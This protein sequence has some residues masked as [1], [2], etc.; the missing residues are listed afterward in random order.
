MK[1][2]FTLILASMLLTIG[3]WAQIAAVSDLNNTS[4]YTINSEGRGYLYY[5]ASNGDYVTSTSHTTIT[6]DTPTGAEKEQ[7]AFLRTENTPEGH[8]YLYSIGASKF[9]TYTGNNGVA[10]ELTAEPQ[11]TWTLSASGDYF[12]IM[13]PGTD[14]TCINVTNWQAKFGTKV[15]G[16]G[17]DAGNKMEI[18]S[19][20]TGLT[21]TD[22]LDKITDFEHFELEQTYTTDASF[23][24]ESPVYPMG[25]KSNTTA[26]GQNSN[27]HVGA[28]G[29]TI[30]KAATAVVTNGTEVTVTFDYDNVSSPSCGLYVAGVDIVNA[31]GEVVAKDY[32][33]GFTGTNTV[34]E[35]SLGVVP[36]GNYIIRYYVCR[37]A[38]NR[39]DATAGTITVVGAEG[40]TEPATVSGMLTTLKNNA[41]SNYIAYEGAGIGC[42]SS[43]DDI[44]TLY[45][46]TVSE[47]T[48]AAY[49]TA[50]AALDDAM[51]AVVLTLPEEGKFYRIENE[52]ATGYLAAGTGTGITQFTA[53]IGAKASSIFYY[54]GEKLVSYTTGLYLAKGDDNF[55]HYTE[56]VGEAAGTTI[57]FA[58]SPV[59]GKVLVHIG[60]AN[61]SLYSAE[62]GNSNAGTNGTGQHY[63]FTV[64]E[65]AW[66]P[67]AMNKEVGYATLYS[68]VELGFYGRVKAYTGTVDGGWLTLNEQ[69]AVPA[70]TGVVLKLVEGKENDV[71]DGY[72]F[73]PVQATTLDVESDLVGHT[74]AVATTTTIGTPYTLQQNGE[75]VVFR[76]YTGANLSG[77][78]AYL[79]L[80]TETAAIGIRFEDGTTAIDN[81]QLSTDNV[82]IYDLSGRRVEKM[83]KGI[84]IV[85]GKKVIR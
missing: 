32:R 17:A 1:K 84:Y 30:Y 8:Y 77:F 79:D 69:T 5:E 67:V 46:S 73:L 23:W 40:I 65:V 70:N 72:I 39:L 54:T 76:K 34:A 71:E 74:E 61:R 52:T 78:K 10:L 41:N 31:T 82:V 7:F 49:A 59:P 25:L 2:R 62:A 42:Y 3:A 85:N 66:L 20:A 68:P 36:A 63:R 24:S 33:L 47:N 58:K 56:T 51:D 50:F 29:H 53:G 19:V 64:T 37:D 22:A 48:V 21:L 45:N 38:S 27:N 35:Y 15:I 16:T 4:A 12:V 60:N 28:D 13:V 14:N 57:S 81:V 43:T 75:S 80:P 55:L 6:D 11:C 83:E 9:V 18:T 26:N 44:E